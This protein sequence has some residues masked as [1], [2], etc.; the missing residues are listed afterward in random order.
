MQ[1]RGLEFAQNSCFS[2][3]RRNFYDPRLMAFL[4]LVRDFELHVWRVAVATDI[5]VL[6]VVR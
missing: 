4:P 1:P 3:S 5:E 6:D 2:G